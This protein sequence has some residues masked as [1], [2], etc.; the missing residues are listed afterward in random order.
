MKDLEI[1][2]AGNL[3]GVEQSGQIGAVGFDLYCRILRA[4]VEDAKAV[5]EDRPAPSQIP[6]PPPVTV[7][8]RLPAHLPEDYVADMDVR[9]GLYRRLA[10]APDLG[11]VEEIAQELHDRFGPSPVAVANLLFGVRVKL[12]ATEAGVASVAQEEAHI[13]LRLLEGLRVDR[14]PLADLQ[15]ARPGQNQVRL[16]IAGRPD[17]WQPLVEETLSRMRR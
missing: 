17:R 5:A 10:A 8:L 12:L 3:L 9:L 13:V 7:D 11:A 16:E 6:Q 4:A 1:R 2:G 15:G 14:G